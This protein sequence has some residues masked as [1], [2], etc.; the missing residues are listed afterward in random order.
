MNKI[1]SIF[2][3]L[4][5]IG[6]SPIAPGTIGSIFSIVFLYFLIKFVSYSF[7]VIIFLIILF[8]SLKL[9]EKYSNL[10][11]SHDSSTIVIDEF[12]GIF[13][14]ILFYDYLKFTNDFIMFLLILILF[15]FF[16]ILKIFP[17]NWV[18]K[19]I[20]NSF[21]VVLDDLLAGVYSIIVLYSINVF[22]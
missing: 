21:G 22:I 13:L 18:D 14:I 16:D 1:I 8:T 5:G 9:I 12:L 19:N 6:Y 20:K 3:T 2:T 7:L 17:I 11:K 15:R 4:F 10:L